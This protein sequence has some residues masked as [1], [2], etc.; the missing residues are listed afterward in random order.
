MFVQSTSVNRKLI[1]GTT[2]LY[3]MSDLEDTGTVIEEEST[4]T[5]EIK[6]ETKASAKKDVAEKIESIK[7]A[8]ADKSEDK[9]KDKDKAAKVEVETPVKAADAS[10]KKKKAKKSKATGVTETTGM[11]E[12]TGVTFKDVESPMGDIEVA[13][14][15][16]REKAIDPDGVKKRLAEEAKAEKEQMKA[17]EK[18]KAFK[19]AFGCTEKQFDKMVDRAISKLVSLETKLAA[20]KETKNAKTIKSFDTGINDMSDAMSKLYTVLE[21]SSY[22]EYVKYK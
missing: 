20:L 3:E 22:G 21:S 12:A 2:F 18:E 1:A 16:I 13:P 15:D 8:K 19:E 6:E 7:A 9:D 4:K 11:T 10:A 5:E 17:K 14:V